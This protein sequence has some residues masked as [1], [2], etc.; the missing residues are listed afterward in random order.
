MSSCRISSPNVWLMHLLLPPP[1]PARLRL[2][3]TTALWITWL[4]SFPLLIGK[5]MMTI[6]TQLTYHS[7]EICMRKCALKTMPSESY[8]R[9]WKPTYFTEWLHAR[10]KAVSYILFH[11]IIIKSLQVSR[12]EKIEC[13]TSSQL[14]IFS[15]VVPGFE[16][17]LI[18]KVQ[19]LK[20]WALWL[21]GILVHKGTQQIIK[22]NPHSLKMRTSRSGE[23]T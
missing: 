1:Y 15:I 13:I 3:H 5:I 17:G 9:S 7:C 12:N 8:A 14:I 16:L 6:A 11:F 10:H 21:H 4:L 23:A 18:F 2:Y 19:V 20:Y 22:L